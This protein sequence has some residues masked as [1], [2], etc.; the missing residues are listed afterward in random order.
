MSSP[1]VTKGDKTSHGGTVIEGEAGFDTQGKLVALVGHMTTCPKCKGGPFPI[2][3]GA[4][5]FLCNG[6][7]VARHGDK[8]ACGASLISG[9]AVSGWSAARSAATTS[10]ASGTATGFVSG[11]ND[12]TVS[13][14]YYVLTDAD[15]NP[16]GGYRYD[17]HCDGKLHTKAGGFLDGR[18]ARIAGDKSTRL[19][20]WLAK[21]GGSRS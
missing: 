7:P 17:L 3:T 13:E 16:V 9:Q 1:W 15:G 11:N 10:G 19:V 5:D 8:T 20:A 12:A 21:D 4:P 2:V 18:T 6:R 14:H